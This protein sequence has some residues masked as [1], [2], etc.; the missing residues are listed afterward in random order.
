MEN[1]KYRCGCK[2]CADSRAEQERRSLMGFDTFPEAAKK[3]IYELDNAIMHLDEDNDYLNSIIN[4][5]WEDADEIIAN[6]REKI[7]NGPTEKKLEEYKK[8]PRWEMQVSCS[9]KNVW[10]AADLVGEKF[11]PL[12]KLGEE[13]TVGE[14]KYQN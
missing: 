13:Y 2:M 8:Y 9:G 6:K 11:T 1:N 4:G 10:V 7:K 3:L 14:V 12:D 5:T